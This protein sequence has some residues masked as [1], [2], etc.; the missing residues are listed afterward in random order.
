MKE[1]NEYKPNTFKKELIFED[2]PF[3]EKEW[4]MLL[5]DKEVNNKHFDILKKYKTIM[6]L[7]TFKNF[8]YSD[9]RYITDLETVE[10]TPEIRKQL[11]NYYN[12]YPFTN[13][14][15]REATK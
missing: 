6:K 3:I 15:A 13:Q 4:I 8:N 9:S 11:L 10:Y 12:K 7:E 14:N 1:Y 5:E 2:I